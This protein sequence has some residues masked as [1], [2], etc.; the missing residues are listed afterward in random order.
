MAAITFPSYAY[1]S[2]GQPPLIVINQAAFN[3]LAG[4]GTWALTPYP[5][6]TPAGAPPI[7]SLASG[8][9]TFTATDTRLQQ[10]LIENRIQSLMQQAAFVITEDAA[11]Q[12]RADVLANDSSLTS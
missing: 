9:G 2:A 12:M 5:P 11:T 3:A 4:P 6:P 7:D 8:T 1:N 10:I